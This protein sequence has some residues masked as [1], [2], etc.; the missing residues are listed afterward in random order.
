MMED[1]E[2][3]RQNI[4]HY[5]ELLTLHSTQFTHERVIELLAEAL[6]RLPAAMAETQARQRQA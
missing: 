3:L 5:R 4:Q 2:T 6:A 1:P